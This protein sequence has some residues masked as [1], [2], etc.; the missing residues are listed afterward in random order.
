LI[1]PRIEPK[2]LCFYREH[3]LDLPSDW[4]VEV[5]KILHNANSTVID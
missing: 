1:Q 5:I 3:A 2:L 4:F